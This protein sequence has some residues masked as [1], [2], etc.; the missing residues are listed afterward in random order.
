MSS[1]DDHYVHG[2][3]DWEQRRLSTLNALLNASSLHAMALHG[4]ERVLDV[5][6]G[7]GQFSRMVARKVGESGTV[8]G[9]ERDPRQRSEAVRQATE[10]GE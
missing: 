8:V 5:G 1:P 10:D 3:E 4:G 9:V 7:L 2:T 6:C